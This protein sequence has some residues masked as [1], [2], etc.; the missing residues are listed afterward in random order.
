[1][2]NVEGR[3][4]LKLEGSVTI[5]HARELF[6]MLSES[7]QDN[8]PLAVETGQLEDVDTSILQLL[9]S[10]RLAVP[11]LTFGEPPHAFLNALDRS[12]LRREL[13]REALAN[14]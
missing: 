3:Q 4:T 7:L 10:L 9:C 14:V 13:L 2:I 5:R 11:E 8:Q 1:M 6:A 12:H